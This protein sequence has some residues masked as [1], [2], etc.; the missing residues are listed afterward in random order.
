METMQAAP[1]RSIKFLFYSKTPKGTRTVEKDEGG[2]K[3][4]YFEGVSSGIALDGHGERMTEKAIQSFMRQANQGN[5]LL[6]GDLHNFAYSQDIGKLVACNVDE[7]GDWVTSYRLYD[8]ADGVGPVKLEHIADI[9]KQANGLPPYDVPRSF[10]FSIEGSIPDNGIAFMDDGGRRVIDDVK[11]DGTL[12]TP[13]PAYRSSVAQ[14]VQ[15]ALG[16]PTASEIRKTLLGGV[17]RE[18]AENRD[19]YDECFQLEDALAEEVRTIM[20]A[21]ERDA[22]DRLR[23]VFAEYSGLMVENIQRHPEVFRVQG[24]EEEAS[25][26]ARP[27]TADDDDGQSMSYMPTFRRWQDEISKILARVQGEDVHAESANKDVADA[28]HGDPQ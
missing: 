1:A 17:R 2:R 9:W 12:L 5:I 14:A 15:K 7:S 19:Y 6:Y 18:K 8:E 13:N 27:Y 24:E 23:S 25:E 22:D 3:R 21:G 11:L 10:G 26:S 16:I 28:P 4:R 20:R